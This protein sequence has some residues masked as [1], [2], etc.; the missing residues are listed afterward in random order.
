MIKYHTLKYHINE[1][2]LFRVE[3]CYSFRVV[4]ICAPVPSGPVTKYVHLLLLSKATV[5]NVFFARDRFD[6]L[7][8]MGTV[9]ICTISIDKMYPISNSYFIET[10]LVQELA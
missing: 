10:L 5:K 9:D 3:L 2:K 7:L 8:V 4:L 1:R 6:D